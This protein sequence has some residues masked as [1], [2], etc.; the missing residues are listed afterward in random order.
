[1]PAAPA[2]PTRTLVTGGSGFIGTNLVS[3]L[4]RAGREILSVDVRAPQCPEHA[5]VFRAV[6]VSDACRMREVFESWRPV[7]VVHLAARTDLPRAARPG[8][9]AINTLGTRNILDAIAATDSVRR[10]LIASSMVLGW[11]GRESDDRG[12]GSA[13]AEYA[14][15]KQAVEAMVHGAAGVRCTWC[16]IRPI[17][18]WGPWFGPPYREFFLRI[19]RRRYWHL[20]RADP[21]KLLGYVGNVVFQIVRL[22]EEPAERV[23]G[24][25]LYLG[26]Y[27][28]TTL[29]SW[30][31]LVCRTLG[32]PRPKTIPGALVHAAARAGD[33]LQACGWA[34][35][36]LTSFRLENMTVETTAYP[37]GPTRAIAGPLP[38]SLE[39]GVEETI[40]WLR[41]QGLLAKDGL[42]RS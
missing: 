21:G 19:A 9:Y 7:E 23:H 38:Y 31:E 26:D 27:E 13:R 17:S 8:D 22:L 28:P 42:R 18:V 2:A 32:L 14:A 10:V 41:Q 29:R 6:D 20:G 12:M 37:I 36:P 35:V 39:A 5:A 34:C 25:T 40:R 16:I 33:L 30:S 4:R 15:S 11:P 24:R 3:A 1:M